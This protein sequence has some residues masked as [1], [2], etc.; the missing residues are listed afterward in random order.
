M[1]NQYDSLCDA[2]L[3]FF[4]VETKVRRAEPP[5]LHQ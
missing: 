3:G 1:E 5:A 4:S 2:Q